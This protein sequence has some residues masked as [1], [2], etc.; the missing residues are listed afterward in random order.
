MPSMNKNISKELI[1]ANMSAITDPSQLA[2]TIA[3]H[4]S[5]KIKDKQR[6]LE[7]ESLG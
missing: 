5:F 7:T 6:L 3:A 2:D 1:T 4:F